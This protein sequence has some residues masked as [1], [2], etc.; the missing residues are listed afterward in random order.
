MNNE[1]LEWSEEFE[2]LP[3]TDMTTK[4]FIKN[5]LHSQRDSIVKIAESLKQDPK[6]PYQAVN[7][8]SGCPNCGQ[9]HNQKYVDETCKEIRVQAID[10]L[11]KQINEV[12][13]DFTIKNR[14]VDN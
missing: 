7:L 4:D 1:H 11:I 8:G 3:K 13:N 10:D 14:E 2:N 5:L 12:D 9:E 6:F